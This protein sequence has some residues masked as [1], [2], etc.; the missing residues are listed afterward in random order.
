L[1]NLKTREINLK[2]KNCST[3]PGMVGDD[4]EVEFSGEPEWKGTVDFVRLSTPILDSFY[5]NNPHTHALLMNYL[6]VLWV[7]PTVGDDRRRG[8]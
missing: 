8:D 1:K 2:L 6:L 5:Q 4:G 7:T 3:K